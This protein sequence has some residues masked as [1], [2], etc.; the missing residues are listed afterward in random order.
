MNRQQTPKAKAT[1]TNLDSR[2]AK[3]LRRAVSREL[4]EGRWWR[5]GLQAFLID[6]TAVAEPGADVDPFIL[7]LFAASAYVR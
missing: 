5:S 7:H 2:A 6:A 1:R 4:P 3:K